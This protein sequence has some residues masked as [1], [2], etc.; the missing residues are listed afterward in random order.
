LEKI[1][2]ISDLKLDEDKGNSMVDS[3]DG[4][5]VSAR[6]ISLSFPDSEKRVLEQISFDIKPNEK[7]VLDGISG[8][9]KTILTKLLAGFYHVDDGELL[10]DNVPL[11]HYYM[12]NYFSSIGVGLPTNQLFEGSIKDNILMGREIANDE[13]KQTLHFLRLNDFLKRQSHG[14]DTMIDSGGRRLPRGIIQKIQLARILIH[15]PKLLLLEEPLQF[16]EEQEKKRIIDF[17]MSKEF[18][19]TVLVVSDFYYW[20]EKCERI[21]D[22]N[23]L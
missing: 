6:N 1:G 13:I 10:I 5:S 12:E 21:I 19:A 2:H 9:G 16:I 20:K 18:N 23:H 17:L 4:L 22:L 11:S 14:I 7:I 8:S 3:E 15:R